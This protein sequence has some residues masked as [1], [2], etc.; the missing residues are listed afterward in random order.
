[1]AVAEAR[2]RVH[3][4]LPLPD[5][6]AHVE[7]SGSLWT[8]VVGLSTACGPSSAEIG[9]AACSTTTT[10]APRE[11]SVIGK[12][13]KLLNRA[14]LGVRPDPD[15]YSPIIAIRVRRPQLG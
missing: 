13:A 15:S 3:N 7:F 12:A 4:P 10:A 8:N 5:N 1:M 2:S 6:I 9:S 14:A 11:R